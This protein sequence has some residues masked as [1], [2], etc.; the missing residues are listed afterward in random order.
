[1]EYVARHTRLQC[2]KYR[3]YQNMSLK[4]AIVTG[5]GSGIGKA[6]AK[7]LAR[8]DYYVA[9][10]GRTESR[11]RSTADELAGDSLIIPADISRSDQVFSV[12]EK[13]MN[14][15]GR[16][17]VLI[18]NAAAVSL[19]PIEKITP[20]HLED[21]FAVNALG[22]AYA[23]CACWPHFL[24]QKNGCVVNVSS[25][26]TFDPFPGFFAYAASKAPLNL[27]A[28]SSAKEGARFGIRAFAVAP[29]AVETD[30]LRSIIDKDTLPAEQTLSPE[31][32]AQVIF[33]CVNGDHDDR[34]GETI[35]VSDNTGRR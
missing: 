32:V 9:L 26:A 20:K 4:T 28:A 11:L 3:E 19:M 10:T 13:V 31:Q 5:A 1:M 27:L 35:I 25:M 7:L 6:T 21:M 34:S 16:V 15:W 18:N 14:T 12:V 8:N 2:T 24:A 17:D 22:P 23:I 33:A 29:G 30:M